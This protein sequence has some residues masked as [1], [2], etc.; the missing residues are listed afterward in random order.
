MSKPSLSENTLVDAHTGTPV[1]I[2]ERVQI[3]SLAQ[4][5]ATPQQINYLLYISSEADIGDFLKR[6]LSV[7]ESS[8]NDRSE[9]ANTLQAIYGILY[10]LSKKEINDANAQSIKTV[11]SGIYKIIQK[12]LIKH[13]IG[14]RDT[15]LLTQCGEDAMALIA[16]VDTYTESKKV[17]EVQKETHK[18]MDII[19]EAERED[20]EKRLSAALEKIEDAKDSIKRNAAIADLIKI[21]HYQ[22]LVKLREDRT[23]PLGRL[24]NKSLF[25]VLENLDRE[26]VNSLI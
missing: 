7:A 12:L 14:K 17:D 8:L 3:N 24:A 5:I 6:L 20:L 2:S 18:A 22:K 11:V 10:Y 13:K 25:I 9:K 4:Q 19:E 21:V 26:E 15:S 23:T 16:S 1:V